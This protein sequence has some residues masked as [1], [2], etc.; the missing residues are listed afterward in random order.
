MRHAGAGEPVQL[1]LAHG[2]LDVER[3]LVI[4]VGWVVDGMLVGNDDVRYGAQ[5]RGIPAECVPGPRGSL[6][7]SGLG[8]WHGRNYW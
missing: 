2:A 6:S 8:F 5:K 1:R 4:L 3:Q 7:N